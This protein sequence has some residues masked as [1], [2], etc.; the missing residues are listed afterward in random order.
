MADTGKILSKAQQEQFWRNGYLVI[1]GAVNDATLAKLRRQMDDWGEESREHTE[2]YGPPTVDGRPRF[3][4]GEEHSAE[5]P[6]LRRINNPCEIS[7]N[8]HAVMTNA[9]MVD[10]V[11][12]LIGPD[13]KY[14]HCKINSKQPGSK[15][16]VHYH[17]VFP[18]TP[19]TNDDVITALLLLDD[20]DEENGCLMVVPGTHRGTIDSLFQG[21]T[22]TGMVAPALEQDYMA[23]QVPIEGRAGSVCLMHTRLQHGSEANLSTNRRRGIYICVYSAADAVPIARNPMPSTLEG[24]IVRGEAS[25]TARMIPLQV[26]LPQQPKSASF[27]TVIGQK[28]AGTSGDGCDGND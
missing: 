15:M 22:F 19:H 13:V 2:P 12:D 6:A 20:V 25:R 26:E 18:Y 10:M 24:T 5:R 7:E 11:A 9:P 1:D 3:D 17:Q 14:H 21:D 27:F 4:M 16:V 23:R 8:F 28:S